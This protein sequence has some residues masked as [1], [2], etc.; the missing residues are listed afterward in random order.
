MNFKLIHI[1]YRFLI[2]I[3]LFLVYLLIIIGILLSFNRR[4]HAHQNTS[5]HINSLEK[6]LTRSQT[7]YS[8]FLSYTKPGDRFYTEGENEYTLLFTLCISASGDSLESLTEINRI[9]RKLDES[10][11]QDSVRNAVNACSDKFEQI[12][13]AIRELGT[14]ETGKMLAVRSASDRLADFVQTMG[15][16]K[17]D[18]IVS[19]L[20]NIEAEF[21]FAADRSALSEIQYITDNLPYEPALV[22]ADFMLVDELG[23]YLADYRS[24]VD[25][26]HIVF[27]RLGASDNL[28][29][30]L[31]EM[32]QNYQKLFLQYH[33]LELYWLG[34]FK[35][36]KKTL[37]LLTASLILLFSLLYL[38]FLYRFFRQIYTPLQKSIQFSFQISK[39]KVNAK[40]VETEYAT[41]LSQLNKNL[42]TIHSSLVEKK[43]FVDNLLKQ[44]FQADISLQGRNDTFGKTLIALKENMRKAREEQLKYDEENNI[45]RYQNEGIAKFSDILRSNSD[46]LDKL[47]DI[48]IKEIVRYLEAIQGGLFL[49]EDESDDTLQLK[50]A[51]A[52]NRKK[53]ITKTIRKGESLVGTCALEMKTINLTALPEDYIEI[54][55]GLGDAPPNNLLILPVMHE[56]VLIGVLELASLKKFDDNQVQLGETITESLASSILNAR[57]NS[58]TTELLQKSQQQAAEMAEQEEE[59]RQNMEELKA[60]Q[61]ESARREEDLEGILN[62]IDQSFYVI[63]YDIDGTI[64]KV[65]ER[66]LYLL[67][68]QADKVLGKTHIQLFGKKSKANS[69]LFANVAEGNTVELVEKVEFNNKLLEIKNTFS[70]VKQKDGNTEGILNIMSLNT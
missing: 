28:E 61:E 10:G 13:L 20:K 64:I 35:Q 56:E 36:S 5:T 50:A 39:G 45:R 44:K 46:N 48:F 6:S 22:E 12:K 70:P 11:Y 41:E 21:L 63:E 9:N 42:N 7:T 26:V 25:Q 14:N 23:S 59:M 29:S 2:Q 15:I 53:Y 57:V 33:G 51:F 55:S 27:T 65:N 17:L 30:L 66:F 16:P 19:L 54:T 52:Y 58:K 31:G 18:S 69:I 32:E 60:T 68:S 24:S 34:L 3:L 47:A 1:K 37:G 67:N 40:P 49:L 43:K 8:Q 38:F 4:I 62:A